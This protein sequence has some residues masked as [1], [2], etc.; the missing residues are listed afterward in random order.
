MTSREMLRPHDPLATKLST[1]DDRVRLNE[2][3]PPQAGV[4]PRIRIGRRWINTL[5]VLPL[6]F[7]LLVT[8]VAVAQGLRGLPAVNEFLARYPG[9]P[10][11]AAASRW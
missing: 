7:V 4:V 9:A 10:A 8:G 2:W 6:T 1:A 11:S 5:W 3:L